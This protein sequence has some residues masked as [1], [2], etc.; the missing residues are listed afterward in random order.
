MIFV[1]KDEDIRYFNAAIITKMNDYHIELPSL[2]DIS[3]YTTDTLEEKTEEIASHLNGVDWLT[4]TLA[5]SD[6]SRGCQGCNDD[7]G[8]I[9]NVCQGCYNVNTG[10]ID[11]QR[12]NAIDVCVQC[13]S[14]SNDSNEEEEIIQVCIECDGGCYFCDSACHGCNEGCQGAQTCIHCNT[15]EGCVSGCQS[16]YVPAKPYCTT[17]YVVCATGY[18]PACDAS[19]ATYGCVTCNTECQGNDTCPGYSACATCVSCNRG[20]TCIAGNTYIESAGCTSNNSSCALFYF[21]TCK[22]GYSSN[23]DGA[24][25][26]SNTFRNNGVSCSLDYKVNT[27]TGLSCHDGFRIDSGTLNCSSDFSSDGSGANYCKALYGQ[28]D[29]TCQGDYDSSIRTSSGNGVS[30]VRNYAQGGSSCYY[31]YV[32][33][34]TTSECISTY[35]GSDG[36]ICDNNFKMNLIDNSADCP[37]GFATPAGGGINCR[38]G[39]SFSSGGEPVCISSYTAQG[40]DCANNYNNICVACNVSS[41]NVCINCVDG[42]AP[43]CITCVGTT[44]NANCPDGC[45]LGQAESCNIC[46]DGQGGCIDCQGCDEGCNNNVSCYGYAV[47]SGGFNVCVG[48]FTDTTCNQSCLGNYNSAT[49][50]LANQNCTSCDTSCVGCNSSCYSCNSS[51]N[52]G[53]QSGQCTSGNETCEE[54]HGGCVNSQCS[55]CHEACQN[56]EGTCMTCH[57]CNEAIS[58]CNNCNIDCNSCLSCQ[59]AVCVSGYN[60]CDNQQ[61]CTEGHD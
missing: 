61:Q 45:V 58:G 32:G 25:T 41:D 59:T 6:S 39:Y 37:N 14:S 54:C 35:V 13:Y 48:Q 46:V 10:C 52:G 15:G 24:T 27:T 42:R 1:N 47:A 50:C 17:G 21:G 40:V 33:T 23:K 57:D 28:D 18:T 43:V 34:Q 11:C 16:S 2:K 9:Y 4:D 22:S 49:M 38:T 29:I 60:V 30:C 3:L 7:Y 36:S 19:Q 20:N 55:S 8:F 53:C 56:N 31:K 44:N 12:T 5:C 26:C 51:C